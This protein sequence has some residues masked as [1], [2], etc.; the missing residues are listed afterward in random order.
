MAV[1]AMETGVPKPGGTQASVEGSL[2]AQE[3]GG[4]DLEVVWS[5]VKKDVK[6]KKRTGDQ[7]LARINCNDWIPQRWGGP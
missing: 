7:V 3:V 2:S 1:M 5:S 6:K 4:S